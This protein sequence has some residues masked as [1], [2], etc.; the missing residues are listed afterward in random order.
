MLLNPKPDIVARFSTNID[1]ENGVQEIRTGTGDDT[2][3]FDNLDDT[4]AGFEH[5]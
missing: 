5:L 3:I 4:K 2:I 1:A